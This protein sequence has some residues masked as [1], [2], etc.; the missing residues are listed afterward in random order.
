MVLESAVRGP[1]QKK[2]KNILTFSPFLEVGA[3]EEVGLA[4]LIAIYSDPTLIM[5]MKI[6]LSLNLL[7]KLLCMEVFKAGSEGPT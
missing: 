3:G 6:L 4:V 2:R 7:S 1:Q 5:T